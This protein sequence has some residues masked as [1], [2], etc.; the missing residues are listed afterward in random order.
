M[1][2]YNHTRKRRCSMGGKRR[3]RSKTYKTRGGT[4][5]GGKK[6]VTALGAAEKTFKKTNS[7]A[8][9]REQLKSQAIINAQKLFGSVGESHRS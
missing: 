8:K 5:K 3:R 6:W 4:K 9:A 1:P 2:K 7:L